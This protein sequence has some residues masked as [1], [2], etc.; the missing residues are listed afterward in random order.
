ML[1]EGGL[2]YWH[3]DLVVDSSSFIDGTLWTNSIIS[4]TYIFIFVVRE[5]QMEDEDSEQHLSYY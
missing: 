4:D 5:R 1:G 3:W 2:R